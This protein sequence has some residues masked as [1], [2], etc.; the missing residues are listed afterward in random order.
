MSPDS[1][2][3]GTPSAIV[4]PVTLCII[5]E[6]KFGGLAALGSGG[7]AKQ[8]Y[9]ATASAMTAS[10]CVDR[11]YSKDRD[12]RSPPPNLPYLPDPTPY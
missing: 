1:P 5:Q 7:E 2:R 3:L 4:L 8:A 11:M 12:D 9:Q 10:I 6:G